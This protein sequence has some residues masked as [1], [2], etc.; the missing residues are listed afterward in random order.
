MKRNYLGKILKSSTKN[1]YTLACNWFEPLQYPLHE[2]TRKYYSRFPIF[3]HMFL[4]ISGRQTGK[5]TR[6]NNFAIEKAANGQKVLIIFHN[7]MMTV[8]F[9]RTLNNPRIDIKGGNVSQYDKR[10][11]DW[12]CYDEFDYNPYV[13]VDDIKNNTYFCTTPM[14]RRNRKERT[15]KSTDVLY[16]L[17]RKKRGNY[18]AV[19]NTRLVNSQY[20]DTQIEAFGNWKSDVTV[21]LE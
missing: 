12:I 4:E 3:K 2:S 5:T 11:Y 21:V 7:I 10:G 15:L 8:Q 20:H 18:F 14:T 13:T 9:R 16:H 17:V 1:E 6:L 19:Y